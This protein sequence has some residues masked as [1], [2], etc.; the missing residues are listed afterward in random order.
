[1]LWLPKLCAVRRLAAERLQISL[2]SGSKEISEMHLQ[3]H[4]LAEGSTLNE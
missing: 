1:V 4:L 2:L 3:F